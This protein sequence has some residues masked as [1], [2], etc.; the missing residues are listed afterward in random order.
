MSAAEVLNATN[1]CSLALCMANEKFTVERA[2]DCISGTQANINRKDI[3]DAD[4][5]DMIKLRKDC[6]YRE[7][8]DM[9]GMTESAAWRR[10]KKFE[11]RLK[12]ATQ[13]V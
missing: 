11:E 2:L 6:T 3:T 10:I 7:I 12:L 13:T 9:Y 8:G 5:A 4:T 1:W